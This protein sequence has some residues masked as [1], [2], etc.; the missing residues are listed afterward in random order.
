MPPAKPQPDELLDEELTLADLPP[1]ESNE[2]AIR[3]FALTTSGYE[4]M[5]SL[6]LCAALANPALDAWRTRGEFPSTLG[7]LR[8]CLFFEQR[9]WHHYGRGFDDETLAYARALIDAMRPL[10]ARGR[11]PQDVEPDGANG[12]GRA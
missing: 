3:Q 1:H 10:V 4:R 2:L 5:G 7:D 9:R 11:E 6:E 8:C 12:P